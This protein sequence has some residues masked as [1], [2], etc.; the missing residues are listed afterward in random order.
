MS[1]TTEYKNTSEADHTLV[2]FGVVKAG[3]TVTTSGEINHPAFQ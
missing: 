3:E 1:T 2:G